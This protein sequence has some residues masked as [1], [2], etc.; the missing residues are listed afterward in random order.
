MK[1]WWMTFTCICSL[2]FSQYCVSVGVGPSWS[3]PD[4]YPSFHP[5]GMNAALFAGIGKPIKGIAT[6]VFEAGVY[7][8]AFW[9]IHEHVQYRIL[10][11]TLDTTINFDFYSEIQTLSIGIR[12]QV[13]WQLWPSV[14]LGVGASLEFPVWGYTHRIPKAGDYE[15]FLVTLKSFSVDKLSRFNRINSRVFGVVNT[16]LSNSIDVGGMAGMQL[17]PAPDQGYSFGSALYGIQ[18]TIFLKLH[19][20]NQ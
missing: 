7:F 13:C 3:T 17:L 4:G 2:G 12:D 1:H 14:Q 8:D 10:T 5:Y 11:T 15:G 6:N 19:F 18:A 16:R 9:R 20:S